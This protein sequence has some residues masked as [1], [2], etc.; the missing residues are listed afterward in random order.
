MGAS[1]SPI[2]VVIPAQAGTMGASSNILD[3]KIGVGNCFSC[4]RVIIFAINQ[5]DK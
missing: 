4:V 1:K 5:S 2:V 3:I